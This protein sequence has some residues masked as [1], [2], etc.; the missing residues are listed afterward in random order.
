MG[1]PAGTGDTASRPPGACRSRSEPRR[2]RLDCWLADGQLDQARWV[3]AKRLR[4]AQKQ[5]VPSIPLGITPQHTYRRPRAPNAAYGSTC[6]V[7]LPFAVKAMWE[8][9]ES[10]V[11]PCQCFSFDGICT[12]SP[13]RITCCSV[14]VAM[15]PLP[16]VTNST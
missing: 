4:P 9:A 11:A 12:T 3:D 1:D 15:M 7:V 14:S 13:G 10:G 8:N 2:A 6:V 5:R 16:A